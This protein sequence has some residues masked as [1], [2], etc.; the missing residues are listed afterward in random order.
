VLSLVPARHD[1]RDSYCWSVFKLGIHANLDFVGIDN[2]HTDEVSAVAVTPDSADH[3]L[4]V[5]ALMGRAIIAT[6]IGD[7]SI[8]TCAVAPNNAAIMDLRDLP[9]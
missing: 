2:A 8:E 7:S 6:F 9:F 4:K 3:T 1:N 5:W